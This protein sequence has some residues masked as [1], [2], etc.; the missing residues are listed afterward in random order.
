MR[1]PKVLDLCTG[2]SCIASSLASELPNCNIVATDLSDDAL[3][4][5]RINVE[6][7]G[8]S[9]RI[10]LVKCNMADEVHDSDFNLLISNPPYVPSVVYT[11]LDKEVLDYEPRIALEAAEDGTSF[12]SEIIATA[13]EKLKTGGIVALEF[14][15]ENLEIAMSKFEA[16]GFKNAKI[17]KDLAGKNRILIAYK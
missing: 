3:K 6:A 12:L 4:Y 7:L 1:K 15:E 13:K 11:S 10:E 17:H 2:S 14:H 8:F 5:A 9:D 16:A